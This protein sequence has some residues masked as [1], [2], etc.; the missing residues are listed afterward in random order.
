MKHI[1]SC[2]TVRALGC[3]QVCAGVCVRVA[4][5]RGDWVSEK[6]GK[7]SDRVRLRRREGSCA[8]QSICVSVNVFQCN[9]SDGAGMGE[10]R[11]SIPGA[12]SSVIKQG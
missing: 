7:H 9:A 2:Q 12:T 11:R 3:G 5:P 8:R 4:F 6:H 10:A 1:G